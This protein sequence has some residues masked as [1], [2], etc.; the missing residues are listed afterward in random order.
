MGYV[1]PAFAQ[2][3]TELQIDIRGRG[4]P[5]RVARLPFYSSQQNE[6]GT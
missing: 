6:K 5:A 3:G 1:A 2:I 4:E